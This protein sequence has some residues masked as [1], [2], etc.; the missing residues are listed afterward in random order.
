MPETRSFLTSAGLVEVLSIPGALPPVLFFP[1][2]HC[3]AKCDCGWSLYRDMGHAIVS[4]S[5]PGYG[6]TRVDAVSPAEF[7]PLVREVC[8]QLAITRVAAAVGV[9][10]GGMQAVHV[11]NDE[12]LG[13]PR[14]VL[15]SC[16]PSRLPYP[17]SRSERIGGPIVFSPLLQGVVW[18][19]VR[20]TVR[21]D[22]GLR[23][24]MGRLSTL[25]VE[26]WWAGLTAED[27]DEA[28]VL[29]QLMGSDAGYVNDLHQ[30]RCS[31]AESRLDALSK[32]RCPT[33]VT[34]SRHDRGVRFAHAEDLAKVIPGAVLVELDSPSH[35]F[36][37]GPGRVHLTSIVQAFI[38]GASADFP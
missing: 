16:A 9:S 29:F 2:G 11:A 21:T 1:G 3:S 32:V 14:L 24:L 7:A 15:H 23:L 25:P 12:Q 5:R 10:F 8:E 4:F 27:R 30:G 26:D 33:L 13:V 22:V 19:I 18:R 17:D 31:G 38:N 28:R 20:R 36:W 35:I 34:G 6:R 37:I